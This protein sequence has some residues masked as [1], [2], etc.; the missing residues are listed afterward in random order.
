MA[1]GRRQVGFWHD[2]ATL[3]RQAIDAVPGN[4]LAHNNLGLALAGQG[5]AAEAEEH[6]RE[7]LAIQPDYPAA[8]H[9]LAVLLVRRGALDEALEQFDLAESG[10]PPDPV[11]LYNHGVALSLRGLPGPAADRFARALAIKPDMERARR[12]L[13]ALERRAQP[14]REQA[15]PDDQ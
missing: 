15:R 7:A 13:A 9:N 14:D 1:A 3:Y 6:Y 10:N 5:L 2:P 8:R 11:A 4:W 12:A